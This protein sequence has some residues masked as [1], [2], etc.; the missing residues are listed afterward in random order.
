MKSIDTKKFNIHFISLRKNKE[1]SKNPDV[2]F[3]NSQK[4]RKFE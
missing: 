3:V 4:K 1:R 2:D